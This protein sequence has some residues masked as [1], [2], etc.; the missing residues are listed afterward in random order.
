M[1]QAIF[2]SPQPVVADLEALERDLALLLERNVVAR[3]HHRFADELS[4]L[5]SHLV[6]V[7]VQQ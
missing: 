4:E 2:M 5:V 6:V 3:D 1:R 7:V